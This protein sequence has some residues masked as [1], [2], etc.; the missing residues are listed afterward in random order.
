MK[1]IFSSILIYSLLF[2]GTASIICGYYVLSI[3]EIDLYSEIIGKSKF[4][5]IE[6]FTGENFFTESLAVKEMDKEIYI[7]FDGKKLPVSEV[8][9]VNSKD[10]N[11][12]FVKKVS[13]NGTMGIILAAVGGLSVIISLILKDYI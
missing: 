13:R 7:L 3:K 9:S 10:I 1:R 12:E 2:G 4:Y 8:K 6:T 5:V 11:G